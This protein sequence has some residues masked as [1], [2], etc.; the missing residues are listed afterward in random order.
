LLKNV[1]LKNLNTKS[2]ATFLWGA[3]ENGRAVFCKLLPVGRQEGSF[4]LSLSIYIYIWFSG[5]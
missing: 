2:P 5:H 1:A 4:S 3:K